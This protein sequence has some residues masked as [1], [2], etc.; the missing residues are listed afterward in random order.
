MP[1]PRQWTGAD[2]LKMIDVLGL[3]G[4][5]PVLREQVS[6][7][8]FFATTATWSI[9]HTV[10]S[11]L[12]TILIGAVRLLLSTKMHDLT[13]V[14]IYVDSGRCIC[15]TQQQLETMAPEPIER[16]EKG[17]RTRT[18]VGQLACTGILL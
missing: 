18:N 4:M 1:L 12:K 17:Q 7:S 3:E 8:G 6:L 5:E 9:I 2:I 11:I 14:G 15:Y 16:S 13:V 10:K